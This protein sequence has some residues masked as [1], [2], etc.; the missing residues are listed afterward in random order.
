MSCRE[1][2]DSGWP[3]PRALVVGPS[4]VVADE[5]TSMLDVSSRTGIMNLMQGLAQELG[6]AYLY[7]THDLAVAR[8]MCHR[9][10]VMYLGKIVEIG[11]TE[12]LLRKPRHPYTRALL[13]AVPLPDPGVRRE[14]PDIRGELT[15]PIDPPD[16]C[17]F[18]DRC[19]IATEHCRN[20]PHPPT[21]E[22]SPG[23]W[24]ACYEV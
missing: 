14:P 16:R 20:N 13:S 18:F 17:R 2:S 6:V 15:T 7:V 24:A 21:E 10:A 3:L 9:I 23:H 5:P 1:A 12:E 4:F 22:K 8:Y 19:P 11:E